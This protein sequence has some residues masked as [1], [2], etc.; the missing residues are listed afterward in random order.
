MS[1]PLRNWRT[2]VC[3]VVLFAILTSGFPRRINAGQ[4]GAVSVGNLRVEYKE[5]PIGI[6]TLKPRLSWQLKS[7][8]RNVL[9][10]A[11]QIQVATAQVDLAAGHK[12]V[13]DSNRITSDES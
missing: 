7:D 5:N 4:P 13:W 2:F 8:R 6:D 3:L 11:Y 1:S 9:Q 12:L 10:S